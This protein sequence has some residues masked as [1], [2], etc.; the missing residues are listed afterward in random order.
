[1]LERRALERKDSNHSEG[2]EGSLEIIRRKD[3]AISDTTDSG[4]SDRG[5]REEEL[6]SAHDR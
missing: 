6:F 5:H 3:S 2:S 4:H 1:M